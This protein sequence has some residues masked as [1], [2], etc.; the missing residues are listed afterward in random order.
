MKEKM[1]VWK[2]N[3]NNG[4]I[5]GLIGILYTLAIYFF[6]LTF[7]KAQSYVFFLIL[8]VSLFYLVKQ[9]RNNS[10]NG[11]ISYGQAV[12][13][14]VI[15]FLYFSV[16]SAIFTYI[17]YAFIDPD[18]VGKQLANAEEMLLQK[19]MPQDTIDTAMKMQRKLIVPEIMAPLSIFGNMLTGTIMSLLVAIFVRK[20]G[21][22]LIDV[23]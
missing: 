3:L 2:A 20:E 6:D 15:I 22:P 12:G 16:I 14:G 21:N 17:L 8:I 18:L 5:L 23:Q 11:Y 13:S 9:Y 1:S 4:L 10:L 19:G 7:N